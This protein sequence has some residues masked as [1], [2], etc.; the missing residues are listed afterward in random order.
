MPTSGATLPVQ[1]TWGQGGAPFAAPAI[2]I[3]Q[4]RQHVC[5]YPI[6]VSAAELEHIPLGKN[7]R[8]RQRFTQQ[9]PCAEMSR[10][11]GRFGDTQA[12]RCF[13]YAEI[14]DRPQ[15]EYRAKYFRE[16]VQLTL[17]QRTHLGARGGLIG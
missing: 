11:N 9:T 16:L 10:A 7:D 12:L 4:T 2:F 15:H 6:A 5:D 3:R 13:L 8:L 1:A 17:K 14:L